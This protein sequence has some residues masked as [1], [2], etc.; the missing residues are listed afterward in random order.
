MPT[1]ASLRVK[2]H[3]AGEGVADVDC[4]RQKVNAEDQQ[5]RRQKE[6]R[7]TGGGFSWI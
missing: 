7:R 6:P 5:I 4:D 1:T 3:A 2:V